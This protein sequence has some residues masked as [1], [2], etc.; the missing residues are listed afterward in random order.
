MAS[1]DFCQKL[2][3]K[4]KKKTDG[5]N[6]SAFLAYANFCSYEP[7]IIPKL[8]FFTF[9]FS[10]TTKVCEEFLNHLNELCKIF[11]KHCDVLSYLH[12]FHLTLPKYMNK[13]N[14]SAD[15]KTS[16]ILL[17]KSLITSI[18]AEIHCDQ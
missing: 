9:A 10:C 12:F 18:I 11:C 4:K 7:F 13:N 15:S 17:K 1:P 8:C 3:S 14:Y 2:I 5:I 16:E 6:P